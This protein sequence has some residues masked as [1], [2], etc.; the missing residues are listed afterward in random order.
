MRNLLTLKN[1]TVG[2]ALVGALWLAVWGQTDAARSAAVVLITLVLWI[3]AIFPHFLTSLIFFALMLIS[4]LATPDRVFSGFASTAVWLVISGFV[5]GS[6]ITVSGLGQRLAGMLAPLLTGSYRRLIFGLTLAAMALGFVMPS[7]TGRAVV[8]V[9]IGM[10]IAD[11]VG[12]KKGSNGRTGIAVALALACNLPSFAILPAN[13]PNMILSGAS[14]TLFGI[15]FGYFDYL[16]LHFPILGVLKTIIMVGLVLAVFPD[17]IAV[18]SPR[19]DAVETPAGTALQDTAAPWRVAVV[20]M[21]TLVLWMTD[22]MHGINPAWI[23]LGAAVI[24]LLPRVGVVPTSSFNAS[25][26]FGMVLFVAA[27]LGVGAVVNATGLGKMVGHA[28]EQVLPLAPGQPLVNFL[29]LTIMSAATGI[30][31][32]IPGVPTVLTP[33]A[34]DL[35]SASGFRLP[36]VLMTQVFGFSTVLFPYQVGPL[37]VALQLSGERMASLVKITLLLAIPTVVLLMPLAYLWWHWLG[38]F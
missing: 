26:D 17:R 14:E 4:G 1:L 11:R 24:L 12:F 36:T 25:V 19:Q 7:S 13:L 34:P 2:A 20:L 33:L 37:I 15:R 32:T 8:L 27:A 28:L 29:S 30:V 23:G 3:T 31:T 5:I 10:A 35:A 21:I 16:L 9:P 38:W 6:A 18:T 22:R